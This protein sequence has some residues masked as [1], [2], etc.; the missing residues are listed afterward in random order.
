M[1]SLFY[2]EMLFDRDWWRDLTY[3]G[4]NFCQIPPTVIQ[5]F[6]LRI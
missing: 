3:L 2:F 5:S 6:I 4:G 1:S